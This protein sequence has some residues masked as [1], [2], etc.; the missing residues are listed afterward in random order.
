MTSEKQ[1][2]AN[3]ANAQ[4]SP[5]PSSPEAKEKVRM[6]AMRDGITGQ[7]ITLSAD[8]LP[9]FEKLKAE[10]IEDFAPKTTMEL[11][12][13][14]SI[15]WDTWRLDHLRAVEMNLY[16]LG[17]QDPDCDIECDGPELHTAMSGGLTFAKQSKR[18]GLLS[19]YGTAPQPN[20][21][22]E[23]GVAGRTPGRAQA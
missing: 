5:G 3:R 11:H 20:H 6:N 10:L 15:A 12:L 4:K 17:T 7:V 23:Y 22:Q 21:P 2:A 14:N 13:A 18:F 8:D 1:I 16:A 19:I 9:I